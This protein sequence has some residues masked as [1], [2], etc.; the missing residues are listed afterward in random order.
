MATLPVSG[1]IILIIFG[2]IFLL[3]VIRKLYALIMYWDIKQFYNQA[4]MIEDAN[5]D[6]LTWHDVQK[7]LI[8]VQLDLQMC[9]HKRE[10]TELDIYHR[11]L[12]QTNYLV[13]LVNKKLLPPRANFPFL[14]E[15]VYW[16]KYLRFVTD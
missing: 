14:G 6:N 10:L 5:L 1:W 4:L 2:L 9:I 8:Q 13:A 11:I 3:S 7:R 12:R 16:T 15:V